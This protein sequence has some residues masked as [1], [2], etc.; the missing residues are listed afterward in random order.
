MVCVWWWRWGARRRG[1]NRKGRVE[2]GGGR[3]EG[4]EEGGMGAVRVKDGTRDGA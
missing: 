1:K 4:G 3:E 2:W